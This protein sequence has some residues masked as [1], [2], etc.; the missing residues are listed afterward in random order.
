MR[1][2]IRWV[3][4]S[5]ALFAIAYSA[6]QLGMLPGLRVEGFEAALVAAVVLGVLNLTVVPLIKLLTLPI[7]CLTFGIFSL[8]INAGMMFLAARVVR[9]FEVATFLDAFLLSIIFAI[10]STILNMLFNPE[11]KE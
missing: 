4:N 5:V 3:L 1:L 7:T 2:L 8:V 11:K 9:G 10:L 6:P